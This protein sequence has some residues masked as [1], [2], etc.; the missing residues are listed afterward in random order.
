MIYD[1]RCAFRSVVV[2][3]F[4]EKILSFSFGSWFFMR[5]YE[6]NAPVAY[7]RGVLVHKPVQDSVGSS[8]L[9]YWCLEEVVH[10][11]EVEV[12]GK[13]S[14]ST[15]EAPNIHKVS[16]KKHAEWKRQTFYF[17]KFCKMHITIYR[18]WEKKNSRELQG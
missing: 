1:E 11:L 8:T 16:I 12:A 18:G 6:E 13:S 17:F 9:D 5:I 7:C 4:C 10:S 15:P 3:F 14:A 2:F